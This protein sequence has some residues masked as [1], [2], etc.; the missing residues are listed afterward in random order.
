MCRQCGNQQKAEGNQ[1]AD[2]EHGH[3]NREADERVEEHVP[4]HDVFTEGGGH[5]AVEGN[6]QNFF[7]E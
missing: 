3:G 7:I 6:K 2:A 5:R 4:K 1:G